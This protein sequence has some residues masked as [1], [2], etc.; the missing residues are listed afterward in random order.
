MLARR[1]EAERA[2]IFENVAA[3]LE[4]FEV[5]LVDFRALALKIRAEISADV[6][7]FVPIQPEPAQAFINGR[8]GFL[9]V[10]LGV[11]VLDAQDQRAAVMPAK[12]Q[13]NKRGARAADMQ[14]TGGRRG[15][16]DADLRSHSNSFLSTDYADLRR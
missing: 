3:V 15:K 4:F 1:T 16:A 13:L 14:V 9:G 8:R 11:G 12:S 10:A 7:A 2:L 6:R 5:A